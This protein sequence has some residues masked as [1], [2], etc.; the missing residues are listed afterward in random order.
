MTHARLPIDVDWR[1]QD[2]IAIGKVAQVV[3]SQFVH[4]SFVNYPLLHI[5]KASSR[6]NQLQRYQGNWGTIEIMKTLLKNRRSYRHRI[7]SPAQDG[8]RDTKDDDN[9]AELKDEIEKGDESEK[10]G[11]RSDDWEA[12][13]MNERSEENGIGRGDG[14]D[15]ED[16]DENE[17]G[18]KEINGGRDDDDDDDEGGNS[19]KETN[20]KVVASAGI[21]RKVN[22]VDEMTITRA[23]WKRQKT[24]GSGG[25]QMATQ[26]TKKAGPK[27]QYS[28]KKD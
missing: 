8:E 18:G 5:T 28:K 21:K 13:Y 24:D 10:D 3:S 23:A 26:S 2:V 20:G 27:K 14:D 22:Q 11:Y 19:E 15:G 25:D 4:P 9:G 16:E 17:N 7:G 12:M 1:H 6:N